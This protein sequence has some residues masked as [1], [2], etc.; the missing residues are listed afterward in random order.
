MNEAPRADS[1]DRHIGH[2]VIV[3]G[4]EDREQDRTVLRRF[5]QLTRREEPRIV[6]LTTGDADSRGALPAYDRAFASLGVRERATLVI[7]RREQANDPQVADRLLG[8]DGVF[9]ATGDGRRLLALLGGTKAHE[10]LHTGFES[11]AQCVAGTGAAAAALAQHVLFEDPDSPVRAGPQPLAAGLG[12]VHRAVIDQQFSERR[13]LA[14]LLGVVAQNPT[15]IGIGIDED[16]ALVI[17]PDGGIEV[18]GDSAVTLVDGRQMSSS[19]LHST[20]PPAREVQELVDV[21][22][23][24]LPAGSR[25]ET[26]S[27]LPPVLQEIVGILVGAASPGSNP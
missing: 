1:R 7:D 27:E 23:H 2:L 11:L 9:V 16:T 15:L 3:G 22:L 25:Y 17:E 4:N 21:K 10:A 6:L 18:V 24:L 26:A 5:V 13:R 8:A 14:C 20:G 19:F 12:L